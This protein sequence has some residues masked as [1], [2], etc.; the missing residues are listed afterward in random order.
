MRRGGRAPLIIGDGAGQL[1][2]EPGAI[3]G[4]EI[5]MMRSPHARADIVRMGRQHL[6]D[7]ALQVRQQKTGTALEIPLHPELRAAIEA[8]P[9]DNMTFLVTEYGRPFSPAGF[10]NLFREW[11]QQAGLPKGYSAHG[12]RKAAR[13]RLA[14][15]GCSANRIMAISGHKSLSEAEKYVRAADQKRLARAAIDTL[16]QAFPEGVQG[17][18]PVSTRS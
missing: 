1:G 16:V 18:H 10:S 8:T 4:G 7:G 13:R 11:C 3:S 6:G 12:L 9:R 14:E 2:S 17:E 15:L 5:A